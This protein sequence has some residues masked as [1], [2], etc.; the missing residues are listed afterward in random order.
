MDEQAS[1]DNTASDV[2]RT[3]GLYSQTD[4]SAAVADQRSL[5]GTIS[6]AMDVRCSASE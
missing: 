1:H 5:D 2:R 3:I 6:D 4:Q